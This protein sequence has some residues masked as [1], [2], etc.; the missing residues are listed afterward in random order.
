MCAEILWA[1]AGPK[2]FSSELFQLFTCGHRWISTA[3]WPAATM[4]V[5]NKRLGLKSSSAVHVRGFFL[6]LLAVLHQA[7]S[8]RVW[9][10]F[11]GIIISTFDLFLCHKVLQTLGDSRDAAF[12]VTGSCP[13][14]VD[15]RKDSGNKKNTASFNH[16]LRI[17]VFKTL[18]RWSSWFRL[19]W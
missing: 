14:T 13:D 1:A 7:N 18:F 5:Q 3:G 17:N 16:P 15:C 4:R 8:G 19:F 2:S 6:A 9:S 12:I 10:V 11:S